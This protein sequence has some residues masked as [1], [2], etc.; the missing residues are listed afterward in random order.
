MKEWEWWFFG[1]LFVCCVWPPMLGLLAVYGLWL[2][3]SML[4]EGN[5]HEQ[6]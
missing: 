6:K 1:L 5:D 4:F 2:G 3:L